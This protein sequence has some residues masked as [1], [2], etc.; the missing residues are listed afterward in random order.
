MAMQVAVQVGKMHYVMEMP[1]LPP[2]GTRIMVDKA[3]SDDGAEMLVEVVAHEW[4]IVNTGQ[5][6]R[7]EPEFN[8]MVKTRIIR[9]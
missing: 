9:G 7:N 4:R 2:I 6:E 8:V 1:C 3:F 5:T